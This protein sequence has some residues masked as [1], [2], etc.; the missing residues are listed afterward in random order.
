M[1]E[2]NLNPRLF[3]FAEAAWTNTINHDITY[4]NERIE[5]NKEFYE[6]YNI[7]PAPKKIYIA[8]GNKYRQELSKTFRGT[9]KE[10]ELKMANAVKH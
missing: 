4:F 7:F 3:A 8:H 6:H 10:V 2:I 5:N 9:E 1:L